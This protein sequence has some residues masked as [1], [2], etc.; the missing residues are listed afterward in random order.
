MP[1]I[2]INL[3]KKCKRCGEKGATKNGLCLKCVTLAL[4]RGE[5]DHILDKHK[6]DDKCND[7]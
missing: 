7:G 5:F 6:K 3:D 2:E 4:Q 1:T